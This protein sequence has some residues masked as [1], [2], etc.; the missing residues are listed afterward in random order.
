MAIDDMTSQAKHAVEL[1]WQ[2]FSRGDAET[3]LKRFNQARILKKDF[4]PAYFGTA[5]VL[6]AQN[7]L[8]EAI[9]YYRT[10]ID[11]EPSF[12][13]AHS[14]LG[15]ALLYSGEKTEA[16]KPLQEAVDL[17]PKDGDVNVN[18]AIWYYEDGQYAN[19]WKYLKVARENG[20]NIK[21]SFVAD[22]SEKMKEPS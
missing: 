8:E 10:T 18:L 7:R 12:P 16:L 11:L 14:N 15:L 4:A 2:Y 19:A 17:A 21:E 3:A 13:H 1:G 6:S 5:Y 22:L 20:A 9:P